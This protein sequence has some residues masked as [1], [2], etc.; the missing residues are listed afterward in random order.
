MCKKQYLFLAIPALSSYCKTVGLLS[1]SV[2]FCLQ[3]VHQDSSIEAKMPTAAACIDRGETFIKWDASS[4][5]LSCYLEHFKPG[6]NCYLERPVFKCV[7]RGHT[8]AIVS[9]YFL[10][11]NTRR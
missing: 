10:Y 6:H 8:I 9:R 1:A 7:S 4:Q 3:L 2:S 5:H 11:D